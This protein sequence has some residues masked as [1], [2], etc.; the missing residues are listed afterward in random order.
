[1]AG[2]PGSA[3]AGSAWHAKSALF[4]ELRGNH[5]IRISRAGALFVMQDTRW[6]H[7]LKVTGEGEGL[8]GHAGAGLLRKLADQPGLPAGLGSA[9]A[10]A[11]TCPLVDRGA[12]LG[13]RPAA[14]ALGGATLGGTTP[15]GPHRPGLGPAPARPPSPTASRGSRRRSA[16]PPRGCGPGCW[17]AWRGPAP[18]TS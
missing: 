3:A 14:V 18:A 15:P 11:G 9:L 16:R 1:M 6:D 2:P 10:R 12:P 8:V 5:T 13:V 7:G 4:W 17:S